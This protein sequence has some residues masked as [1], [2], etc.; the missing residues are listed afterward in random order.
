MGSALHPVKVVIVTGFLE[1]TK[2]ITN[3]LY[4]LQNIL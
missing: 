3:T 1:I 2:K 4:T